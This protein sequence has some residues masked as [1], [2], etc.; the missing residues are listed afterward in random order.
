[1]GTGSI[2]ASGEAAP[3]SVPRVSVIIPVRNSAAALKTCLAALEAQSFPRRDF[4]IIVVDNGST[5]DIASVRSGFPD[6]IWLEDPGTGSYSA[7]NRGLRRAAGSVVAFTDADCIPDAA[8]L[9][10]GLSVLAG[11]G[12]T[13]VGGEV[14]W[15]DPEGRGLNAYEILETIMFALGSIRQLIDERGFAITANLLAY[16]EVFDRV[17]GFD[18]ALKSAG[19]REWVLRAV[20]RGEVLKYA[21]GAIVRHPR[22]ST[23][24]DFLRKQRRLVGGRMQLLRRSRPSLRAVL[25]DLRKVSLL[26]PRVY[27]VAFGDPRA[28]GV[29]RRLNLIGVLLLVSLVTTAEKLRIICGGEPARG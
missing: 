17:G 3:N 21:G 27:K 11:K 5:D 9:S 29:R 14:P 1:V 26:D 25:A 13:I 7:R 18:A 6:V 2:R 19:D 10:E 15:L 20:A 8:W 23:R 22:R 4:E 16:R 28:T 24:R 12:A